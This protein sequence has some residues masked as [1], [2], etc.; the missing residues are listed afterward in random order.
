MMSRVNVLGFV[1]GVALALACGNPSG[2]GNGCAGTGAHTVVNA[3]DNQ[4]FAPNVLSVTHGESV[5]WQNQGSIAHTVTA[6]NATIVDSSWVPDSVNAQLN[7]GS[8]FLRTF[9]KPGVKYFYK[10]SIHA[11][12]TGEIDVL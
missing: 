8:L 4:T 3:Q 5:C 12:M 9:S 6:V 10:C 1:A 7:P 11:G 2:S